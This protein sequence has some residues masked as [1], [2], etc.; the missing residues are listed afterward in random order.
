MKGSVEGGTFICQPLLILLIGE[1]GY[2]RHVPEGVR[3]DYEVGPR[4][5][6]PHRRVLV[7]RFLSLFVD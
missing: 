3:L 2:V 1:G 7:G 5:D 4:V 6:R